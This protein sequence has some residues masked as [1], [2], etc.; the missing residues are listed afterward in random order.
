MAV[1]VLVAT[2]AL[3]FAQ[4]QIF[5]ELETAVNEKVNESSVQ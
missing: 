3:R 1:S 4:R 2:V 5:L